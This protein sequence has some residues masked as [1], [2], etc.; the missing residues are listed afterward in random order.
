MPRLPT[1][2]LGRYGPDVVAQG[3]GTMGLSA[4]YGS[5]QTDEERFKVLD[6]AYQLG[7]TNWDSADMYA[8]SEELIGKWFKRTGKRDEI[9]LATKF[10][11]V[12]HKDGSSSVDSS[13]EYAKA[14]CEKSLQRLGIQTIDLYYCHR[15]D[16]KTPI[17][18]T[19]EAMAQLKRDGKIRYL[20]LSEVSANTIRRAEKVHH[21]DAVQVE[22]SPF[23]MEIEQNDVLKTCRQLGIAIVA[24]SP[25]GRGFLTGRYQSRADFEPSDARLNFPRFSEENFSKNLV[26]VKSIA[27]IASRKGVTPGQLTLSWLAAQGDDVI[28]IPGTKKIKYLEENIEALRVQ[29]SREEER[30]IRTAI[31][32]V[33]IGGAR[34]PASVSASLFRD[35]PEF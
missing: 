9:F 35:T 30:E 25:L 34:Y 14:A 3:L 32:K 31:E 18:K 2:K 13:P 22:Y 20:G 16:G 12:T 7:Q 33:E 24:Y 6:R 15:V 19:V 17:E 23:A 5:I 29:L 1:R 27:E 10:A 26:L 4:F 21:I 11:N 28:S 8:D